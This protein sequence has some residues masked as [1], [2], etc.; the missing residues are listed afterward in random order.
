MYVRSSRNSSDYFTVPAGQS[1][2]L[3]IVG[4]EIDEDGRVT[5]TNI[6]LRAASGTPVAEII[7]TYG[8]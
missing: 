1:L 7:G 4:G 3:D 2:S 8:G 5:A 6:W